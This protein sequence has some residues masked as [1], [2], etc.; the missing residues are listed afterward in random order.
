[1]SAV[2][3]ENEKNQAQEIKQLIKG[4]NITHDTDF[5]QTK[6]YVIQNINELKDLSEGNSTNF[7][8]YERENIQD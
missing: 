4:K 1:M 7:H 3:D 2:K 5:R 6:L 8:V